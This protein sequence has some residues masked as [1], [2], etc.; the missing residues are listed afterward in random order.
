MTIW[1]IRIASRIAKATRT[2][3][4]V[5]QYLLLFHC[6]NG[7]TNA[8]RCYVIHKLPVLLTFKW[9]GIW[10]LNEQNE[11]YFCISKQ[12]KI[13][14]CGQKV[15]FFFYF[16][17][18]QIPRKDYTQITNKSFGISTEFEYFLAKVASRNYVYEVVKSNLI[19]VN[20]FA[21]HISLQFIQ[22]CA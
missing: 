21:P 14:V 15:G 2:V 9:S 20:V 5:V 8:P 22:P 3:Q 1:R 16:T 12:R 6:N 4:W 13:I 17:L 11:N 19:S 7:C 18:P 10:S